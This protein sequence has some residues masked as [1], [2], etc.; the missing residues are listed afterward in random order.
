MD[1]ES[2]SSQPQISLENSATKETRTRGSQGPASSPVQP[3]Q[4]SD[5]VTHSSP[6][7]TAQSVQ[8]HLTP[9]GPP[10]IPQPLPIALNQTFL[11]SG[12]YHGAQTAQPHHLRPT[13]TERPNNN[14]SPADENFASETMEATLASLPSHPILRAPQI[15]RSISH[16]PRFVL[17]R[18]R[19]IS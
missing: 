5:S 12:T 4:L 14:Q 19:E 15:Q 11:H 6:L 13:Y 18:S 17:V 7:P 8:P 1:E 3:L 2:S 10:L 9:R 16:L